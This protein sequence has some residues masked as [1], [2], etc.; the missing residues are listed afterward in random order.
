MSITNQQANQIV[1]ERI[2]PLAE[3]LRALKNSIDDFLALYAVDPAA[4]FA[5]GGNPASSTYTDTR[6]DVPISMTAGR[7]VNC[8]SMFQAIQTAITTDGQYVEI[9]RACVRSP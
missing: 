3:Q 5:P 7:V 4:F 1:N 2:R 8:Q 9:E 6:T